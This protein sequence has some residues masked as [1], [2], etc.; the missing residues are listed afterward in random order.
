MRISVPEYIDKFY[1]YKRLNLERRYIERT[2]GKEGQ[3]K[4]E[5][6][7]TRFGLLELGNTSHAIPIL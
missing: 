7:A 1:L 4:P 3:E 6:H 5:P 2:P